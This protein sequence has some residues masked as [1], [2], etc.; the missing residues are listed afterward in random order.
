MEVLYIQT[1]VGGNIFSRNL[2]AMSKTYASG[3]DTNQVPYRSPKKFRHL[4]GNPVPDICE[5]LGYIC[6][7]I[8]V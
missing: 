7:L 3:G 5:S 6:H 8:H 2:G 4:M 1:M